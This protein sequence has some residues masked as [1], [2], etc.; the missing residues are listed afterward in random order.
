[1]EGLFREIDEAAALLGEILTSP[2]AEHLALVQEVRFHGLKLCRFLQARSE[3]LW[4]D[5]PVSAVELERI[6]AELQGTVTFPRL[7]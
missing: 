5:D 2:P 7:T 1:L 6:A 4:C 3:E